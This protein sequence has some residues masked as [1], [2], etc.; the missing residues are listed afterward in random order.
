MHK[1][2]GT[3]DRALRGLLAVGAVAGS[4][5]LGFSS[6]WGIVLLAAAAIMAVTG[7]SGYCPIYSLLGINTRGERSEA[8]HDHLVHLDRA[9]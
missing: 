7:A 2:V 8:G 6:A 9:A 1:T 4:A 5:V 3:T